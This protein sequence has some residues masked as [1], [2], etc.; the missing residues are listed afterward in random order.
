MSR[1]VA[2]LL[3]AA[4][5]DFALLHESEKTAG[6]DLR[7]AGEE[8]LFEELVAH[9]LAAM[10][11]A[12]PFKRI[13]TTDPH[14][15]NTIR[16][17]Y[18]EFGAVAPIDHYTSVLLD[19]IESG[20]L[21]VRSP[22][23]RRVTFHDPCHLGRLNGGY[24]APR[25]LLKLIGCELIEMP[26]NRANSFAVARAAAESGC[27]TIRAVPK[28][29]VSRMHEAAALEGIEVFV[30]CCPKDLTMYEDARKISVWKRAS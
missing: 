20:R 8:G 2:K 3:R 26:R 9:N 28:P 29:S 18:P 1:T 10:A 22:L 6:N 13:M 30:T 17:E 12:E 14:S 23:G 27:R 11:S 5:V 19:L 7:R 24:D 4:D 21:K 15:Y 16:N 25:R